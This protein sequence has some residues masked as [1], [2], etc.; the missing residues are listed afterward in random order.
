M[1]RYVFVLFGAAF[2][3]SLPAVEATN[4]WYLRGPDGGY[5]NNVSIDSSGRVM[6]GGIAGLFRYNSG[7]GAWDYTNAGMPTTNVGDIAQTTGTTF[8]NSDGYLARTTNGGDTW[9]NLSSGLLVGGQLRSIAT[10]AAAPSRVVAVGNPLG[11]LRSDNLGATWTTVIPSGANAELIRVSPTNANLWFIANNAAT[12]DVAGAGQ[13]YRTADGGINFTFI[14]SGGSQNLPMQFVDVA[15]DPFDAN[16]IVALAAPTPDA[17]TD[18]SAGGEVWIST[19]AGQTWSGPNTN[20]FVIAPEISG[21]GEPRAVLFDRFTPNVTYAATTWGVFKFAGNGPVLSSTGMVQMGPRPSGAQPY[22]EVTHLAQANDGKLYASTTSGGVYI[23]ADGASTWN[24]INA[25]YN[26]VDM[27]SFAFQPGNSGVVLAAAADP[28]N[29]GGIYRSVNGGQTWTRSSTGMNAAPIRGLAFSPTDANLVLAAG[30]PQA[31]VGGES[32]RGLWRSTD[33][34]VTW[35]PITD[36][37]LKF[38]FK[39]IVIFDPNNGN[40][41]LATSPKMLNVSQNAGTN[42]VNS[43]ASPGSFGGLPLSNN[44]NLTLTGLAAGPKSG[45]GTRYY[46]GVLDNQP[47]G[48]PLPSLC[49]MN[50][51]FPCKGGVYYSDDMFNWTRATGVTDD[52]A[53]DFSVGPAPGTLFVNQL[54][55]NGYLGGAFKSSDYGAT[56]TDITNDLPCRNVRLAAPDPTDANVLWTACAFA[57][58]AHPG[59]MFRSNNAGANWVPY[60]R[61]LRD[62]DILWLT[63]DPADHNHLLAGGPEGID[64]MHYATDTDQDGIPDADEAVFG[65]TPGDAN[66]DGTQDS[67]QANVASAGVPAGPLA[68]A[69]AAAVTTVG[70]YVVVEIDLSAPHAGTCAR[71][72]D[73]AL[74][75]TDQIPLSNRMVQTA[76]TIRFILPDCQS[77]TVKVRYSAVASYPVGVLGSYSPKTPGDAT[78]QAWGTFDPSKASVDNNGLWSVKLDQDSYGNVYAPGSGA[79]LFQGAP[80]NDSIFGDG[81]D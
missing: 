40:N 16:H 28:S 56:W 42:W 48:S 9:T 30:M 39:R 36:S 23:S 11:I 73:L 72:S 79:I 26:G 80:G 13:L 81:F 51:S 63:V 52:S 22:D 68:P 15:Q 4:Q 19:D 35:S 38:V 8:V 18:K 17:F 27:R 59:G 21:G 76:P 41:V 34:G 7:T 50:P 46:L 71:V 5:A 31:N 1:G 61:G 33:A 2:A 69:R 47:A 10:T 53:L 62:P 65:N 64:E 44:P 32:N 45:G 3:S 43:N 77:A 58:I 55:G 24:A 14:D 60:G 20:V 57:D 37:G 74:V 78:T 49:Q 70:D 6:A 29:I 25:G 12:A 75:P 67:S 66:N 54:T